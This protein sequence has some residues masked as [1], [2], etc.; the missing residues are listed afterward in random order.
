M[1]T[2]PYPK[3]FSHKALK[4]MAVFVIY[5]LTGVAGLLLPYIGS[6]IALIWLPTGV[7]VAGYLKLGRWALLPVALGAM[8]VNVTMGEASL[9]VAAC[10]MVGNAL[11]PMLSASLI[12][13]FNPTLSLQ[14]IAQVFQVLFASGAGM[15]VS[16][17]LGVLTLYGFHLVNQAQLP[18]AWFVWWMGDTCGV[19]LMLPVMFDMGSS[20]WKALW[21]HRTPYL[22]VCG[23]FTA[24]EFG[25]FYFTTP[26]AMQFS[27]LLMFVL[28]LVVWTSMRFGTAGASLVVFGVSLVAVVA[29]SIAY[30][31][32]Y[33]VDKHQGIITLGLYMSTLIMLV[34][35]ISVLLSSRVRSEQDLRNSEAKLRAVIDGAIDA[36]VT[37]DER[38]N[39]VEFNPAAERM[40]QVSRQDAMGKS[41]ASVMISPRLRE[42]H[43]HGHQHYMETGQK[44][45]FDRRIELTAMRADGSEFPVEVVITSLQDRGLN[46]LTGFIRDITNRRKAEGEIQ[47]LAFYDALTGLPN[48][49]LLIDRLQRAYAASARSTLHGAIMFID[50][51]NFKTLNDTRGHDVGDMLLVEAARRIRECLREVDT[52]ARLGGD[53]FVVVLEE[54]KPDFEQSVIEAKLV[55]EKV[56]LALNRA[57]DLNGVDYYS[58]SSIGITLFQGVG[59]TVEELLKRADTA[60]YEAKAAGRNNLQF[61]DPAMQAA[62]E[63]RVA[64]ESLLR[65]ALPESQLALYYQPI[66]DATRQILGAEALIRWHH[67]EKGLV[68]PAHFIS[69]AEESGLII[70]IGRWVIHQACTQLRHWQ[71]LDKLQEL[72]VSVNVSV[73]QFRSAGFVDDV[74]TSLEETGVNPSLLKFE[75][76]E[77]LVINDLVET[78]KKIEQ[79]QLLGVQF[80]M[81]DFGTGYS[82]LSY[83][84]QLPL[85][86]VKIDQSFV[87][88]ITLDANDASIIEAIIVMSRTLGLNVVAEGVETE[89]QF[90]LLRYYGCPLFQGYLF[91]RPMTVAQLESHLKVHTS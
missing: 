59:L 1:R 89:Q 80:S 26:G 49:R 35:L 23:V 71:R 41:L 16:S 30:G 69:E 10:I 65:N 78:V 53:E 3:A 9:P 7:A 58:S 70:P 75:L 57:Y 64:L 85:T 25:V 56:L 40:F 12:R 11:G 83:L 91:G 36:V 20:G 31:P 24:F 15:L 6:N 90:E 54:L 44:R 50:L 77:S 55:A 42:A 62:I 14:R 73:R 46:Y 17:S 19:L 66:V 81:D 76:T 37:M 5:Y 61:F 28:P 51:D 47:K 74:K 39:I 45:I 63:H 22:L 52:V 87:R 86:Q 38:G 27:L 13:H 29:T 34:L 68:T 8:M 48:R 84:K 67:P 2:A 60:M 32:F 21:Q 4:L 88:D 82:S 43:H 79:L 33:Q 72:Q 18:S